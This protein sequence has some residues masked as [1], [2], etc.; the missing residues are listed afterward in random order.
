MIP[1]AVTVTV[2]ESRDE[3]YDVVVGRG[4]L[5]GLPRLL[6]ERCPAS[7]Y[8]IIADRKVAELHG[9]RLMTVLADAGLQ[10]HLLTFPAGEW[11]KSREE[12]ARLTDLMLSAH[13]GRDGAVLAF[14]GGVAGDLG[15]FVAAT[16]QRGVPYVQLPTSL[17]AMIDSS[18]GGKTGVDV[19]AG[20]NL[21]GAFHQPRVVVADIDLLTSLPRVQMCSGMAEAIKHGIIRDAAYYVTLEDEK[22]TVAR[23]LDQLGEIVRRSIEI[24]AAVVSADER[25]AGL[26]QILNFGH[27]VGHAVESLSGFELLHGEAVAIGM[28]AELAIADAAGIAPR[29][30]RNRVSDLLERYALPTQIPA[31]LTTDALMNAMRADKKVRAGRIRLALPREL[32]A[33]TQSDD[34]AWTVDVEERLMRQVLDSRC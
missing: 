32:G 15:G 10:A 5:A 33:M 34:G 9:A 8:A 23:D 13:I 25:E 11:N 18:V 20:K 31:S 12:W 2:K 29:A 19:P 17:L 21:V 24:K 4:A 16:Y 6:G 30:L 3:S 1:I 7:R 14:G 22:P 26:R 28:V 27:T